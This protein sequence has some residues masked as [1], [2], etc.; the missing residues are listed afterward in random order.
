MGKKALARLQ[1]LCS[2]GIGSEMLVPDLMREIAGPVP[3]RHGI[4]YWVERNSEISNT[5]TTLP[6]DFMDLFYKEFYRRERQTAFIKT[7]GSFDYW[8]Q[9]ASVL[10]LDD[11]LRVDRPTFLRSDFYNLLWREWGM[12]DPLIVCVRSLGQIRAVLHLYR[13]PGEARFGW[14]DIKF[15]ESIV[16]FVAHGMKRV[17]FGA[18]AFA[19]GED[20]ALLVADP[21]GTVRY[22]SVEAQR[23]LRMALNPVLSPSANWRVVGEVLPEL[24]WLG[25]ALTATAR[26]SIGQPPPVLRRRTPWAEFVLRAYW[27]GA[28]DGVEQTR[29]IG[30][31]IERR[32][33]RALALWRRIEDLPLTARERELCLL[34]ARNISSKDIADAMG[35]AAS[36][37]VTHQRGIYSKLNVH[38]RAGLLATLE[39]E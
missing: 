13:A 17:N 8:P 21:D 24:A 31:T 26:G 19:G 37:V 16:G 20:S 4:F 25:H 2:L 10:R 36:T 22:A 15:L 28:T 1:R 35:L 5:Y 3:F 12:C 14:D 6:S 33:P 30:I 27:L 18:D 23:L 32:V 34:L 29:Q 39:S 7:I 11:H 9:A 38:G